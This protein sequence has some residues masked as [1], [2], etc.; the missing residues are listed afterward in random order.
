MGL[1]E[2]RVFEAIDN[3]G[4]YS[5]FV[6]IFPFIHRFLF[7]ALPKSG[8]HGYVLNY[9]IKQMEGRKKRLKDPNTTDHDGP[10]DFLTKFLAV[11]EAVPDKMSKNDLVTICLT[12]I[13]A[14]S[15]TTAI[16]LSALFYNLL[17]HPSSYQRLQ[18]EID[19]ATSTG[20][21]DDPVTFKQAQA[22]PYLQAVIKEALRLHPATGLGLQRRVPAAHCCADA[23]FP[24]A[25][26][27]GSTHGWRT[28]TLACMG[29]MRTSGGQSGG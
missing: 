1:D 20:L 3:R 29:W 8:G 12:N 4:A 2:D 5:T 7:P 16:T 6:G 17:K 21:I 9:S 22:L 28:A 13:A 10:Q 24:L 23:H 18:Q 14:G 19:D 26:R 27:W 15:D 11:H 25:R